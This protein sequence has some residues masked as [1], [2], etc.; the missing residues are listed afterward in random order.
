MSQ[1]S[2]KTPRLRRL[3]LVGIVAA[4]CRRQP[5]RPMASSA[6]PRT[7]RTSCS[8]PNAQAIPTV[9]LAQLAHG[10]RRRC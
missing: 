9:A 2:V 5:S 4:R 10:E 6:G 1:Q 3:L 7:S 8:G